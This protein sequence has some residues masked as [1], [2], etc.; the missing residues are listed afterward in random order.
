MSLA[1]L[2]PIV[3]GGNQQL[4]GPAGQTERK[5]SYVVSMPHHCCWYFFP[6]IA[7]LFAL[8]VTRWHT[9]PYVHI[10]SSAQRQSILLLISIHG[11]WTLPYVCHRW[12]RQINNL[13][14]TKRQSHKHAHHQ[15][16]NWPATGTRC[17]SD[18][19]ENT[20]NIFF[21][22]RLRRCCRCIA[23]N[24]QYIFGQSFAAGC[25]RKFNWQF[26]SSSDRGTLQSYNNNLCNNNATSLIYI[27][28]LFLLLLCIILW[29]CTGFN[30]NSL[31]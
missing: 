24:I 5:K 19:L 31:A 12:Q 30:P 27:L 11:V 14:T 2:L 13:C 18:E 22:I 4:A 3:Y 26:E 23:S 1:S 16:V 29:W 6:Y 25:R 7:C 10:R 28:I 9:M 8:R 15:L 20:H 17:H 21:F